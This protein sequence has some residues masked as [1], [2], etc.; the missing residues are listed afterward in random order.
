MG[1][2]SFKKHV[3]NSSEIKQVYFGLIFRMWNAGLP[4]NIEKIYEDFEKFIQANFR[5]FGD[6]YWF[7][8]DTEE[9]LKAKFKNFLK[10]S[11]YFKE[12]NISNKQYAEGVRE[13]QQ[14]FAFVS[15]YN[16]LATDDDFIDLDAFEGHFLG[17]ITGLIEEDEEEYKCADCKFFSKCLNSEEKNCKGYNSE[18]E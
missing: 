4:R 15:A 7:I 8:E 5:N 13:P 14:G 12:L 16:G 1:N 9:N 2:F 11:Q 6:D 3:L 18:K 10:T 17:R